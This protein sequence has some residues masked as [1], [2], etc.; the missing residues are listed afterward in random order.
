MTCARLASFGNY[1]LS[2][3]AALCSRRIASKHFFEGKT[4][5]LKEVFIRE[6]G[7]MFE[8]CFRETGYTREDIDHFL[9]TRCPKVP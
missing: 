4:A 9:S 7:E 2:R 8:K 5:E 6:K 1:V 3:A